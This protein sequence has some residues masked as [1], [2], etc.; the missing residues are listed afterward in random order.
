MHFMGEEGYYIAVPLISGA[1]AEKKANQIAAIYAARYE[2]ARVESQ[3]QFDE[4][5]ARPTW[6]N[7]LLNFAEAHFVWLILGFF[8]VLIPLLLLLLG[9]LRGSLPG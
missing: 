4:E 1:R 3:R 6:N 5:R 8:F 9:F 2:Q 7:R